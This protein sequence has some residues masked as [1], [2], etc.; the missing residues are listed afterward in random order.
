MESV[1]ANQLEGC[2]CELLVTW[3]RINGVGEKVA[4]IKGILVDKNERS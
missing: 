1:W 4:D 3:I 2:C